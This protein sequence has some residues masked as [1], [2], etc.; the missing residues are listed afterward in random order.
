MA[1][2]VQQTFAEQTRWS[3]NGTAWDDWQFPNVSE[4][5]PAIADPRRGK[6]LDNG[7]GSAG[8]WCWF[9]DQGEVAALV[10]QQISHKYKVGT[11]LYPHVH[12]AFLS[13]PSVGETVIWHA[14]VAFSGL[15]GS[16]PANTSIH[17]GTYTCAAADVIRRHVRVNLAPVVSG[18]GLGISSVGHV[19]IRRDAGDTHAPEV[20]FCG[21][22][23]HYEIDAIGSDQT[24][25]K[26]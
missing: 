17:S 8:V 26:G 22:D 2:P 9:F 13:A 23:L 3:G 19:T 12:F 1:I 20:V 24:E 4:N 21:F 14:E 10:P 15:M 25:T 5:L 18:S 6:W 11:D 7:A 16:F